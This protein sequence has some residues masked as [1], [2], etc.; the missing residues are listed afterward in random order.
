V[1]VVSGPSGAGKGTVIGKVLDA[2]DGLSA[3]ISAT[4]RRPRPGEADRHHYHFMTREEFQAAVHAGEFLE[5]VEYDGNLYGTLRREVTERLA[6]GQDVILEI[7]LV[8]ARAVHAALP[9]AVSVFVAPPTLADLRARLEHRGTEADETIAARLRIAE[10]E[11]AAAS[12]FD[13]VVVN[14]Q[15]E[16][17]A[18]ELAAIITKTRKGD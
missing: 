16:Q 11:V 1:F 4:T 15:A 5:W 7:E 3:A 8:G 6:A 9:Q 12:E 17:A 18:A 13:F 2:V 10:T 14:D